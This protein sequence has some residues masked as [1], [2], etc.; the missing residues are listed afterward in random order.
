MIVYDE[1]IGY[2]AWMWKIQEQIDKIEDEERKVT[3]F[4]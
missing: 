2:Y 3:V 1:W 4:Y